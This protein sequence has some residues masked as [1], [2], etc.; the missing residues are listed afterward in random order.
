MLWLSAAHQDSECRFGIE[1][2]PEKRI[3]GRRVSGQGS[4]GE[5]RPTASGFIL[6]C[7]RSAAASRDRER[8]RVCLCLSGSRVVA[9]AE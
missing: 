4:R 9:A 3:R 8:G 1:G 7:S 2:E 6:L 5:E